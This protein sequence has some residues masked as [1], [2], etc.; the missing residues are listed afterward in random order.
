MEVQTLQLGVH[1]LFGEQ[2]LVYRKTQL[3]LEKS[4]LKKSGGG[5][6]KNKKQQEE[7]LLTGISQW[8]PRPTG[9][10]TTYSASLVIG[11]VA[12]SWVYS[13]FLGFKK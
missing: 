7:D 10:E 13:L 1:H 4:N 6:S 11:T 5:V 2:K 9:P 8:R 12:E 3:K